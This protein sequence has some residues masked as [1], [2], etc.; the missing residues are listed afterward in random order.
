MKILYVVNQFPKISESFVINELYELDNR[1]HDIAVFAKK[2]PNEG[3]V[4]TE[5][6]QMDVTVYYGEEPSFRSFSNLISRRILNTT[7]LEQVL[8]FDSPSYHMYCLCLGKQIAEVV[9]DEGGVDLVHAHFATPDRLSVT[10]AA[11]YHGI[12]CTVTG[13]AHEIFSPRSLSRLQRVCSR[14]DRII[15]PSEYN[16][17]YL[18]EKIGINTGISVVPATTS[19]DKFEPSEGCIQGRLLTVARLTEKKGYE[20][21]IDAIAKLIRCGYDLKYHIVGS[22]E[23]EG[24]LRDRVRYHGIEEAVEFLGHVSDERL[25]EELHAA[26]VF[27]LPCVIAS[28]GDRDVAPVALKEAMATETACVSTTVSAIPELI[29]HEY[30]GLLVEPRSTNELTNKIS[31]LLNNP[32]YRQKLAKNGRK[33]VQT[34]FDISTTVGDL[35]GV[36]ET[37]K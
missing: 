1:G 11:A 4:H 10:Y 2:K 35:V 36:F 9:E 23:R 31:E 5:I 26:E 37:V 21:A 28:N 13:H 3:F 12:P 25:Q 30:D 27:V 16:R 22:G 7:I 6:Q 17:R 32:E 19:V 33:T 8:F 24:H 18:T 20:Y 14:F 15:T 29:S 34:Q